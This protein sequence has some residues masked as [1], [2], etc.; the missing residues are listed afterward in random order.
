MSSRKS[1]PVPFFDW[2]ALYA[3]R[4]DRFSSILS[5]TARSGGFILQGAV[6][7]FE[8]GLEAFLGGR[9]AIGV[10]DGTNA[11]LLGLRAS[12]LEPGA[13]VI[14]PAH[15][16]IAAAQAIHFAGGRPVPV[17]SAEHDWLVS[18][19]AIERAITPL[20]RAIMVVHLNG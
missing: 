4:A 18:P 2:R 10:S 15:C 14:L 8:A 13:E 16:F 17:E 6:D 11:M 20:T 5:D 19:E 9:H 7:E 3:E 12:R 1:L